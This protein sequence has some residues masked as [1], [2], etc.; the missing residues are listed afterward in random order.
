[1]SNAHTLNLHV[2]MVFSTL[3][4]H[5]TYMVESVAGFSDPTSKLNPGTLTAARKDTSSVIEIVKLTQELTAQ[6]PTSYIQ[7][8]VYSHRIRLNLMKSPE[9]LPSNVYIIPQSGLFTTPEIQE[10]LNVVAEKEKDALLQ[11]VIPEPQPIMTV[12]TD[13]SLHTARNG[14]GTYAWITGRG[15]YAYGL[16]DPKL[17]DIESCEL[18]AILDMLNR[19]NMKRGM[20]VL[21]DSK[22]A[23]RIIR[24]TDNNTAA[25]ATAI[26]L[27]KQIRVKLAERPNITLE[28][29]KAH[30]GNPLND[31]ADRLARN[32][33]IANCPGGANATTTQNIAQNIRAEALASFAAQA[34]QKVLV[35]A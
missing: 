25:S 29:V 6:N 26:A 35:A 28:W 33:R 23:L 9:L 7:L 15:D 22:P 13:A 24:A 5:L 32:A 2:T 4:Q 3:G 11:T 21:V 34:D 14:G 17:K 16:V 1:M 10:Y 8:F 20:R 18:Y 30:N 27:A 31:G 19:I 12:A